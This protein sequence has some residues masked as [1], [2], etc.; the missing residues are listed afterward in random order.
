MARRCH[1]RP[2]L[3]ARDA[4]SSSRTSP[5]AFSCRP[6]IDEVTGSCV[7]TISC[8]GVEGQMLG[9][10]LGQ[11]V[12]AGQH[13][14]D[15]HVAARGSTMPLFCASSPWSAARGPLIAAGVA[16]AEPHLLHVDGAVSG[17]CWIC[18]RIERVDRAAVGAG[19]HQAAPCGR[20]SPD[21]APASTLVVA[22]VSRCGPRRAP[23]RRPSAPTSTRMREQRGR[24]SRAVRA[25]RRTRQQVVADLAHRA[26]PPAARVT[27]CGRAPH[28]AGAHRR[29]R[30]RAPTACISGRSGRSSPTQAQAAGVELQPR[31]QPP[32]TGELVAR[33]PGA[34]GACPARGSAPPPS[35]SAA[36][37]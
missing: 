16:E 24:S 14:G 33:R 35:A 25:R 12:R 11:L 6:D 37:R 30:R 15:V 10:D 13:A 7:A 32:N 17:C 8:V 28:L 5:C 21:R 19:L 22:I 2:I 1:G 31:A 9:G 36:R 29:P 18:G 34:R 27:M 3:T 23:R 20:S 4:P 26:V